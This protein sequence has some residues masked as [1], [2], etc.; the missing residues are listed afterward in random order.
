MFSKKSLKSKFILQLVLASTVLITIISVML[1]HYIKITILETVVQN[2]IQEANSLKNLS[3][4]EL[5]KA[6]L[7]NGYLK[8]HTTQI[9]I[10]D[11]N[12]SVQKPFF[13]NVLREDTNY[14]TLVFPDKQRNFTILIRKETTQYN[15]IIKQVLFDII[16]VNATSIL[17]VLFYALFLSR[18]LLFPIKTLSYKLSS[19]NEGYLKEFDPKDVPQEF[20]PLIGGI[21]HLISRIQTFLQYQKELFIGVAHELKTPLAVMKTKN[22]V[23]LIKQRDSEK[24][25]EALK[26][27]NES[28]NKMN[29]MINS[30]LEI[31]RQEGAQFEEPK[32]IDIISY[33]NELT[34]SFRILSHLENIKISTDLKPDK[35]EIMIQQTLF[36][37][38]I[39]NFVQNAI[40]FSPPQSTI[41]I[42]SYITKDNKF[43]VEVIDEGCGIDENK[44]LFAPF[45]RSGNKTG[46]GL[47]LFL[48]LNAAQAIGASIGIKNKETKD[49]AISYLLLP[50]SIKFKQK[51]RNK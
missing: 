24:Y 26:N 34:N 27:N 31:G 36:L 51:S 47:G 25:I 22:E 37:H 16:V 4:E 48:A 38:I 32:K 14:L 33:I 8:D 41:V 1:Y 18:M 7:N 9:K 39:Q 49:G 28:I 15:Q 50:L 11:L 10:V 46:A 30:V 43:T 5:Q 45:V 19:L 3:K 13:K 29:S 6:N 42:K 23:T 20:I 44:D 35:L 40:K 21:N 2:I 17:L 12:S